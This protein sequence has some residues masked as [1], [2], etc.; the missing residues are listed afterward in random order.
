ML[1]YLR[2]GN[3]RIKFIWW[4]LIVLTVG[5]FLGIFVTAYDPSMVQQQSGAVASVNGS[6]ITR[7]QYA[8]VLAE[9]QAQYRNQYGTEAADQDLV[10][11]QAQAWRGAVVQ[12][13][14]QEQAERLGLR[15][16]DPEIVWTLKNVPPTLLAQSEAFRTNGQFDPAKYQAALA[17]PNM[18]WSPLEAM[19]REQLPPRKL[20][21]R[22]AASLKLSEPELVE[23]YRQFSDRVDATVLMVT[24][25][26]TAEPPAVTDAD[27]AAAYE[28]YKLRFVAPARMRAE[29]LRVPKKFSDEELRTAREQAKSLVDR[30]RAGE[31]F[32]ALAR[33]H[34]EGP[35]AQAGG[36][37]ARP[38][39]PAEFGP[40]LGPQIATAD[41]GTVFDP[42]EQSGRFVIVKLL[43]RN[44]A[45]G[46]PAAQVQV[47]QIMVK[48]RIAE[49]S[50]R[51]QV[52]AIRKIRA[53]AG[54]AGLGKAAT[55]AG[56]TTSMSAYFDANSAPPELADSPDATEWVLTHKKG[57]LS[58]A[59]EGVD[60]FVLA[61]IADKLE[62]G[63][64]PAS[65]LNDQLRGLAQSL[66]RVAAAKPDA[67]RVAQALAQG[68]TLEEAAAAAG[69]APFKV[70]G[71]SRMQPDPRLSNAP[72][73]AGALFGAPVGKV[74]GPYET[75]AA[76]YFVRTDARA[77][78]DTSALTAEVRGQITQQILTQRQQDFYNAWVAEMRAK[79]N[80]KD[81]RA[82]I[83]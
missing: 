77:D 15:A 43:A 31:S 49:E 39:Q 9:A 42:I 64:A 17:D 23:R 63:P 16:Y 67:D 22:I 62:A 61:Q 55:E 44:G 21:E 81:L 5:T 7:E 8:N 26:A 34:S 80:V 71:M 19:T 18:N 79:A 73:V 29:V 69:L 12:R 66:K 11:I 46:A 53:R 51:A 54:R 6:Q 56:L 60:A 25:A 50:M 78:A 40:T 68:R 1:K 38:F 74:M 57:E 41:T 28:R 20:Q 10:A 36:A 70:T 52:E 33:D 75:P 65:E 59:F 48:A 82:T 58:P 3:K 37:I 72:E 2:M 32:A 4:V 24:G 13:I 35:G 27:I 45:P 76:W 47:A 83:K 14:M 30:I